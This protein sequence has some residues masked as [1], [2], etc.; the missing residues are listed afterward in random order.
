MLLKEPVYQK[1]VK[2]EK[3]Q[4]VRFQYMNNGTRETLL[5]ENESTRMCTIFEL[6]SDF[7]VQ[8]LIQLY[9]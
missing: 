7:N 5:T 1:L 9:C 8:L 3:L 4:V 2:P 6:T